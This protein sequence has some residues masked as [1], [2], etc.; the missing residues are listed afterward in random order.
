MAKNNNKVIG[1]EFAI[2]YDLIQQKVKI[3]GKHND[4][5][6]RIIVDEEVKIDKDKLVELLDP[7]NFTGFAEEQTEDFLKDLV[8][9]IIE[10]YKDLLGTNTDLKV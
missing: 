8:D 4:L 3:E 2:S 6:D 5:I 1:G 10:K 9:P 7:K